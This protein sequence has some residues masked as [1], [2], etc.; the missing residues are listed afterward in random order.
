MPHSRLLFKLRTYNLNSELVSW[1]TDFLRN[2][3]QCVVLNE[4]CSSWYRVMSGIPQG[5][6][7][8]PLLFL[9]FINHLPEL[10]NEKDSSCDIFLYADDSKM[11]KSIRTKDDQQNLQ[12]VI[13]LVQKWSDKWLLKLNN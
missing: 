12:S 3:K 4:E 6:I 5:S 10:C 7:L 8:G 2:R 9:I 11:Y 13:D 1:I